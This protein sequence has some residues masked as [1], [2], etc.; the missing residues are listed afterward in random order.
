MELQ[1]FPAVTWGE[2]V[3]SSGSA[4]SEKG[5]AATKFFGELREPDFPGRGTRIYL[6]A[7][8]RGRDRVGRERSLRL[9]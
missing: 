9:I 5:H 3:M 6:Y 4:A 8:G 7:G 1:E 2:G